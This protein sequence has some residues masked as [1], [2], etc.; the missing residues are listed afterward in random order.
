MNG[1]LTPLLYYLF[2]IPAAFSSFTGSNTNQASSLPVR[3]IQNMEMILMCDVYGTYNDDFSETLCQKVARK[4]TAQ[5]VTSRQFS[6]MA[7]K[8][9][10]VK[11]GQLVVR[12]KN[13]RQV[14][15]HFVVGTADEWAA[16]QLPGKTTEHTISIMDAN[17]LEPAIDQIVLDLARMIQ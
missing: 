7:N 3:E 6:F 16:R 10:N 11:M 12:V 4:L 1:I 14:V 17:R 2:V 15:Y 8:G 5:V 9:G 13:A